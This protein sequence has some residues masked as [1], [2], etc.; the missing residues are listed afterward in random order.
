MDVADEQI[1]LELTGNPPFKSNYVSILDFQTN[2]S[3][4]SMRTTECSFR[5]LAVAIVDSALKSPGG[6][7]VR[8]V[9]SIES[10]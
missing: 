5:S 7:N 4:Q 9:S 6:Q 1:R 10:K 3:E 8:F 2:K